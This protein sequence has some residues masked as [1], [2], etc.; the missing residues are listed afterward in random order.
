MAEAPAA[1]F[2]S[3]HVKLPPP[4][5]QLPCDVVVALRVKPPGQE[6]VR[7]TPIA[8]DGPALCT[9]IVY[10][11]VTPSPAATV[12]T[13]SLLVTD[14]SSLVVTVS[15]SLTLSLSLHVALP[16]SV[17]LA[18]LVCVPAGAVEGTV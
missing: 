17:T 14:K 5:V 16:I 8:C 12:V 3:E 1:R 13:P 18:V 10:V 9:V 11:R 2:P 6:S 7:D 4:E 15:V